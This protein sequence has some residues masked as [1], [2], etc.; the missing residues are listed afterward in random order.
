MK[1]VAYDDTRV[2]EYDEASGKGRLVDVNDAEA[3]RKYYELAMAEHE[4]IYNDDK[5]LLEWARQMYP[6]VSGMADMASRF[7]KSVVTLSA[8]AE[9]GV[10]AVEVK[11]IVE[12]VAKYGDEI[13]P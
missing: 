4:R 6:H 9:V 3:E 13:R 11:G 1:I 10:V 8:C 5:A 7:E 2:L 12:E